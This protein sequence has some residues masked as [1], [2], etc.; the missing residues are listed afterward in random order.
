MDQSYGEQKQLTG[1]VAFYHFNLLISGFLT[2]DRFRNGKF[3]GDRGKGRAIWATGVTA[4]YSGDSRSRYKSH[5][6]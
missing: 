4:E 1:I 3:H 2:G 6:F 5:S